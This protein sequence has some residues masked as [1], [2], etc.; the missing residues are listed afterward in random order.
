ML[1]LCL[2]ISRSTS[3]SRGYTAT[4][5]SRV[6]KLTIWGSGVLAFAALGLIFATCS[7]GAVSACPAPVEGSEGA[8]QLERLRSEAGFRVLY[9][10]YLPGAESLATASVIGQLGRQQT[11][12]AFDGPYEMAIRQSQYPPPFRPDP[13]GASR[14][15]IDLFP[16]V[17]ATFIQVNDGSS[18]ALYH[19]YW[20]SAG[21]YYELQAYGPPLQQRQIVRIAMSLE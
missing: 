15:F 10:C 5:A 9:P 4:P 19:L 3:S 6:R 20:E 1:P 7:S 13:A 11:E 12:L 21:F 16:N 14:S 17:R 8:R 2:L 18:R